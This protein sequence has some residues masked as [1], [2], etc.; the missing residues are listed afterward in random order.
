MNRKDLMSDSVSL[1]EAVYNMYY[2]GLCNYAETITKEKSMAE[3]AVSEVFLK[4][5]EARDSIIIKGSLKAYLF[6]S[7]YNQCINMIKHVNVQNKYRG[8][9]NHHLPLNHYDTHYP[10]SYVIENEINDILNKSIEELPY[11]CR[12]IFTMSRIDGMKHE[13]IAN[14]LNI[15]VNT[16]RTHIRRALEKLRNELKDFLD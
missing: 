1:F 13:E 11:K 9:F 7:V 16:V 10:L 6:R 2:K 8:F 14:E 4:M 12:K 15:S 3:D 5:W